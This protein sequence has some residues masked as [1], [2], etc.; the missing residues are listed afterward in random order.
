MKPF[1]L[2]SGGLGDPVEA[3]HYPWLWSKWKQFCSVQQ[4][5]HSQACS[6]SRNAGTERLNHFGQNLTSQ[7]AI[8]LSFHKLME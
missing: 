7:A 6:S 4:R 1:T 5:G 2:E 3:G 8:I